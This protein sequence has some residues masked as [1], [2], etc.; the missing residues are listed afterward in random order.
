MHIFL[1]EGNECAAAHLIDLQPLK[2]AVAPISKEVPL[3]GI[4]SWML[5]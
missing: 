5:P 1:M 3:E 4:T 2:M